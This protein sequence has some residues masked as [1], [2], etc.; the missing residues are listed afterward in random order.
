MQAASSHMRDERNATRS[1]VRR[2]EGQLEGLHACVR[3]T[4]TTL[5][6][7][8]ALCDENTELKQQLSRG[9]PLAQRWR[10]IRSMCPLTGGHGEKGRPLINPEFHTY[11]LAIVATPASAKDIR[12][13]QRHTLRYVFGDEG[14]ATGDQGYVPSEGYYSQL[15]R[16]ALPTA[17]E[18]TAAMEVARHKEISCL[19]WDEGVHQSLKRHHEHHCG[20]AAW[21]SRPCCMPQNKHRGGSR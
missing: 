13:I 21:R 8:E 19:S 17:M 15:R 16:D 12:Q 10:E 11:G 14:E 7:I 4:R 18:A 1:Q 6:D 20:A 3:A 5:H 2:A 9:A